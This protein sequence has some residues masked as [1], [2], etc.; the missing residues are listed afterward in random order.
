MN[1]RHSD[2]QIYYSFYYT[3]VSNLKYTYYWYN[4]YNKLA[5][6][7]QNYKSGVTLNCVFNWNEYYYYE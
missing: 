5:V 3:L 4:Q 6:E 1:E 2:Y 7:K